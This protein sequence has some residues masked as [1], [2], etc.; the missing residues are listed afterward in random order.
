MF[1]CKNRGFIR[2]T[3]QIY[4]FLLN[5]QALQ[6]FKYR[7]FQY[8]HQNFSIDEFLFRIANELRFKIL[9]PLSFFYNGFHSWCSFIGAIEVF[10][11]MQVRAMLVKCCENFNKH[12]ERHL[13]GLGESFY[14][15]NLVNS[16]KQ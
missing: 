16:P 2:I 1:M 12:L 14:I 5:K 6:F 13:L 15:R 7:V 8:C 4:K 10:Y 11:L 9:F 3:N